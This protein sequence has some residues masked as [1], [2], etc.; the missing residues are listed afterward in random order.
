MNDDR[1]LASIVES[2]NRRFVERFGVEPI[3]IGA[4]PGRVNLIGDHVDY[5]DGFVLPFAIEKYTVAAAAPVNSTSISHSTVYSVQ[6]DSSCDIETGKM[7]EPGKTGWGEYIKGVM[8]GFQSHGIGIPSMRLI[9]NSS[10]PAGSGLSSSAALEVSVATMLEAAFEIKLG[11]QAKAVLCQK[12]EHAFTK[13]PCGLMDQYISVFGKRDHL[14]LLDCRDQSHRQISFD[15]ENLALL[16]VDSNVSHELGSSEYPI[17]KE[18]CD[19]AARKLG[20]T[21]LRSVDM[22]TLVSKQDQLEPIEFRRAK[23]VVSENGRTLRFV[24]ALEQKDWVAAGNLMFESHESLRDDYEVSC[25]ELDRLV[26]IAMEVGIEGGVYGARMTGGGFGG[27]AIMLVKRECAEDVSREVLEQFNA[28]T[29]WSDASVFCSRP[30][31][32][33]QIIAPGRPE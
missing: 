7:L 26:R 2:T 15:H 30:A 10:V 12:A 33:A 6:Q 25:Q 24:D 29:E 1:E 21:S 16:I 31:T 13:V 9:I 27:S 28:N 14:L 20:V 11:N 23:H 4:A 32:G 18:R 5:N 19:T 17:R 3:W 8:H 22:T